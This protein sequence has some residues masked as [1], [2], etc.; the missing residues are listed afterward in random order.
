MIKDI[1]SKSIIFGD[2]KSSIKEISKLMKMHN[3]GFIPIKNNKGIAGVI[4]DRDICLACEDI[5]TTESPALDFASKKIIC[6][7]ISESISSALKLMS[8]YKI[9]RLLVKN[10]D[11]IV[12]ILS[13]SD[14]LN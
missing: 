9:K 14:I 6:I 10:K 5:N 7:D 8:K 13:L 1:M 2:E 12:G 3:I 4:T 11:N